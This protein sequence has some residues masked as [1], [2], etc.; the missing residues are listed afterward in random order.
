MDG[1]RSTWMDATIDNET[2]H[3]LKRTD[4]SFMNDFVDLSG[5]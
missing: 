4:I 2:F 3:L 1:L 5:F